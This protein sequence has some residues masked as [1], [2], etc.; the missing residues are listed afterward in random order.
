M[1]VVV[2]HHQR[3]PSIQ[4]HLPLSSYTEDERFLAVRVLVWFVQEC[5][6]HTLVLNAPYRP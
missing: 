3:E 4:T 6:H 1:A 5:G 2:I